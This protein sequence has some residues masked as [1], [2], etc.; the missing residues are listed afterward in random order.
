M[1]PDEERNTCTDCDGTGY[2]SDG[3]NVFPCWCEIGCEIADQQAGILDFQNA[4]TKLYTK[5]DELDWAVNNQ[6]LFDV[7]VAKTAFDEVK[8][9]IAEVEEKLQTVQAWG[10]S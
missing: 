8:D 4:V 1:N 7:K 3:G 6:I 5:A 9:A 10:K 2:T